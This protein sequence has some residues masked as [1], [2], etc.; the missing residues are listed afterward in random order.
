MARE[1]AQAVTG[2]P[3]GWIATNWR[4]KLLSLVLAIGLLGAVAFSENPPVFDTASVRIQWNLPP[5]MVVMNPPSTLDV[6]VAGLRDAVTRYKNGAAGVS[7]D[8]ANA[9][10]GSNQKFAV[11][12]KIGTPGVTVRSRIDPISLTLD[13]LASGQLDIEVRTPKLSPGIAV[14][15]EKTYATCGNSN[16]RCRVS[17][18]AAASIMSSLKAYV[19]YDVSLTSANHLISPNEPI[20]FEANGGPIDLRKDINTIPRPSQTP[21]NVDVQIETRSGTL[22]RTVGLN[23]RVTGTQA[24]GYAISGVD[25]QPNSGFVSIT[26][27]VDTVAKLNTLTLDAVDIS[28]I[29][30]SITVTKRVQ[31]GSPQ[32]TAD[33]ATVRVTVSVNQSFSCAAPPAAAVAPPSPTPSPSP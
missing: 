12:P 6:P 22:T 23:V 17:V 19:N 13:R 10:P 8:L 15:P 28:G 7:I 20:K 27:P 9:K 1:R 21:D 14:I 25:V 32:I 4:L 24:C 30:S 26:G 33:P 3:L 5:E 31:T 29:T 11:T 18:S 16:D 2:T